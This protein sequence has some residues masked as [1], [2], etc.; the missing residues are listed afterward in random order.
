[1]LFKT[2]KTKKCF[3]AKHAYYGIGVFNI[4]LPDFTC[5]SLFISGNLPI[6]NNS[7]KTVNITHWVYVYLKYHMKITFL[8]FLMFFSSYTHTS[9]VPVE[10]KTLKSGRDATGRDGTRRDDDGRTTLE[11]QT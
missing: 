11:G 5:K 10:H 2:L 9:E 6:T 3:K 8:I 1:M 7:K 4:L